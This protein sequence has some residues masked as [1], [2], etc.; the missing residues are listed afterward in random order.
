MSLDSLRPVTSR[1]GQNEACDEGKRNACIAERHAGFDGAQR[2]FKRPRPCLVQSLWR[3]LPI[4][5]ASP[6]LAPEP[7]DIPPDETPALGDAALEPPLLVEPVPTDE[8]SGS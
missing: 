4:P 3:I 5:A 7:D 2:L 6:Q 8:P 1:G